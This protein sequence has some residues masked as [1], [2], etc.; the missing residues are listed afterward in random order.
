M[1]IKLKNMSKQGK[2][3]FA[4]WSTFTVMMALW[5]CW[6][7]A[8]SHYHVGMAELGSGIVLIMLEVLA[9]YIYI[10]SYPE[11]ECRSLQECWWNKVKTEIPVLVLSVALLGIFVL[12][13]NTKG[14]LAYWFWG[15][16]MVVG[17]CVSFLLLLVPSALIQGVI[18]L[19]VRKKIQGNIK[20]DSILWKRY[21]EWRELEV[22]EKR[23][24]KES[25]IGIAIVLISALA[26]V[27]AGVFEMQIMWREP[28]FM[29]AS[30]FLVALI[31]VG[32]AVIAHKNKSYK[33]VGKLLRQIDVMAE[34]NLELE[35]EEIEDP[36]IRRSSEKLCG[37]S[38]NLKHIMEKQMQA[39]RM[40]IDLITNVSHDL[41]TPLTSMIGYIDL[42][43]KEELS[44]EAKDYVEVLGVKQ[45]QL[46]NMIQDIFELSKSTSGT[47][48]LEL[49]ELDMKKLLEQTLGDMED[50][51]AESGMEV[52]KKFS[53][54]ASKFIGDSK[55]MYRV[56]QNLIANALKYSLKGTRIYIEETRVGKTIEVSI[57]NTA[58]YEMDFTEEEVLERFARADK[59]RN[60]EGHGLGL[61]IAEGFIKNMGGTFHV[62][63]DGDQ[64]KVT[65]KIE[66]L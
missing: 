46:K 44:S 20:R 9:V 27:V 52:R 63:I 35:S 8:G 42:L 59:A 10:S 56:F 40:K 45:E 37:I 66:A 26:I 43:K 62:E 58:S 16:R 50:A 57:K 25:R 29:L 64:F 36:D 53:G 41:K 51:I 49:E 55:K 17:V 33:D 7:L 61:A 18:M 2:R 65:V 6:W 12:L 5:Q 30:V 15:V 54:E 19:L 13:Y 48:E 28:L 22:F 21:C 60:T 31:F 38:K 4:L 47:V 3:A 24:Q 1:A 23:L 34:G 39:E 14:M 11:E 32:T